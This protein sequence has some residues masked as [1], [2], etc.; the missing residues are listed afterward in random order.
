[1]STRAGTRGDVLIFHLLGLRTTVNAKLR[2]QLGA[3]LPKAKGS[4][5][6]RGSPCARDLV[7]W[8]YQLDFVRPGISP[9]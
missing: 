2:T 1:V 5:R 4:S 8:D 7:R 6:R 9:L 3:S